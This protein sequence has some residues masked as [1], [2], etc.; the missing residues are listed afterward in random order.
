MYLTDDEKQFLQ[1]TCAGGELTN[2][3]GYQLFE[4]HKRV[5]GKPFG[6]DYW[7]CGCQ[8]GCI[9]KLVHLIYKEQT[10]INE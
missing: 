5:Y 4:I 8:R 6:G 3:Q 7:C 1:T 10:E 9:D 2:E